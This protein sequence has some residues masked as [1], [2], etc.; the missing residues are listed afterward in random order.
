[1]QNVE[2]EVE[3]YNQCG[4]VWI[5]E[6]E[7]VGEYGQYD[8]GLE[9]NLQF[10]LVVGQDFCQYVVNYYFN[11][12]EV[13]KQGGKMGVLFYYSGDVVYG[14]GYVD[15]VWIDVVQ[16]EQQDVYL[17][18]IFLD[19]FQIFFQFVIC[20]YCWV[21]M[22]VYGGEVEQEYIYIDKGQYGYCY[23]VVFCFIGVVELVGYWQQC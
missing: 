18:V 16:C 5:K 23:L 22:F 1:M 15:K 21:D 20:L 12:V 13:D 8:I 4:G 6:I 10:V 14:G 9:E 3:Y 2:Q 7:G 17:L 19:V 11:Y